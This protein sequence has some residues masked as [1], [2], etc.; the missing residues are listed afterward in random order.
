[1]ELALDKKWEYTKDEFI[2]FFRKTFL[3]SFEIENNKELF[4][5][6]IDD[7]DES[8]DELLKFV[9]SNEE[10]KIIY[11]RNMTDRFLSL[12]SEGNS[13][14]R[15]Y[16]TDE[17]NKCILK[18]S[19]QL[20]KKFEEDLEKIK[21]WLRE[22]L[23]NDQSKV[24]SWLSGKSKDDKIN[25]EDRVKLSFDVLFKRFSRSAIQLYIRFPRNKIDREKAIEKYYT[26]LKNFDI[27]YKDGKHKKRG[28]YSFLAKGKLV[29]NQELVDEEGKSRNEWDE[30]GNLDPLF[31]I[32]NIDFDQNEAADTFEKVAK[33][34]RD[35]FVEFI[36]C[37]KYSIYPYSGVTSLYCNELDSIRDKFG[38]SE[39]ERYWKKLI[40]NS[41]SSLNKEDREKVKCLGIEPMNEEIQRRKNIKNKFEE[42]S[43][44]LRM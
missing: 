15:K 1:M 33:E 13:S 32:S 12:P 37:L 14:I 42:V 34:I 38:S 40:K 28:T 24:N 9:D 22:K 6:F 31:A 23:F 19:N 26:D 2:K 27:V 21:A 41:L 5:G 30:E 17:A 39:S 20:G 43:R 11:D 3:T 35:D 16:L 7:V 18:L 4:K 44:I 25:L 8:F 10:M 36:H 29:I